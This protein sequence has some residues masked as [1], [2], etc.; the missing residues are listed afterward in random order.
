MTMRIRPFSAMAYILNNRARSLVLIL[1]M[2]FITVCFVGGMYVDNPG[3][4]FRVSRE[5][6]SRYMT[7]QTRGASNDAIDE[8]RNM[9]K[10][11]PS[12][13]PPEANTI[14]YANIYYT[15]FSSMMSFN[16][17]VEGI[18]FT[19]VEDFELFRERT[20][21]I[22]EDITLKDDEFVMSEQ[23]A[24]NRGLKIGDPMREGSPVTLGAVMPGRGMRIFLLREG[25]GT[26]NMV[27]VS[28]DGVCDAKLQEDLD[29][30]ARELAQKYPHCMFTTNT[31]YVE[32]VEEEIGYMYYIFGAI[33]VVV[34]IVLL[35]T[36]N[37]A[38]TA[39]YDKRKH[40]F[41]IYKALGFTKW[42]IFC[43]IAGEVLIMN[44]VALVFGALVNAGVI[45][46]LNQAL[47]P[48][49]Q[50]FYRVSPM[51][52]YGTVVCEVVIILMIIF[53]NWRKVRKCEVTEG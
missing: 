12:L 45:L 36:I 42:Q 39:A 22:P 15:D 31:T 6:S 9:Q 50:H 29:R 8:Y 5:E 25:W 48:K 23:L 20:H 7:I 26:D 18:M 24:N 51:A 37:A 46:V 32:E 14:I 16:C 10:E 47:W 27:V 44:A 17:N 38:F 19:S 33:V 3:E 13:L 1:M 53:F 34:A 43:K 28:N 21:L 35:V 41:A 40:E 2:S 30:V 49:G 52:V 4:I 11:L